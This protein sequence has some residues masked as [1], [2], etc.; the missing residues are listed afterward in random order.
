VQQQKQ[1]YHSVYLFFK[2]HINSAQYS[3]G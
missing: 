2:M 3:L 1:A